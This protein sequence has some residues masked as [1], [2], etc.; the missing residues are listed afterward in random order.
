[1]KSRKVSR[2]A[3]WSSL[4]TVRRMTDCS[5]LP[6]TCS[7]VLPLMRSPEAIRGR[8]HQMLLVSIPGSEKRLG[9]RLG[10]A[11]LVAFFVEMVVAD[12]QALDL[13]ELPRGEL[14]F[15]RGGEVAQL[16]GRGEDLDAHVRGR[17]ADLGLRV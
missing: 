9:G 16:G 12:D 13:G 1:M 11:G 3:S 7:K 4:N 17:A 10:L 6:L 5:S 14:P 2:K 15:R 8:H